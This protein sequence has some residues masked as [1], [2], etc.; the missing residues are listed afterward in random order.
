MLDEATEYEGIVMVEAPFDLACKITFLGRALDPGDLL[1]VRRG[2]IVSLT[3]GEQRAAIS[4]C[5][6]LAAA[7]C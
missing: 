6:W 5:Q 4:V 1:M 2:D 7:P 3:P